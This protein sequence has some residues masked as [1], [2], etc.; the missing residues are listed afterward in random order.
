MEKINQKKSFLFL[1]SLFILTF[2]VLI[3]SIVNAQQEPNKKDW[4]YD[5]TVSNVSCY[6]LIAVCGNKKVVFLKF[7]N[8]NSNPIKISWKEA[9]ITQPHS[10]KTETVFGEKELLLATGETSLTDCENVKQPK[11]LAR[12]NAVSPID[13]LDIL[14]FSFKDLKVAN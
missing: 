9:F 11:L 7:D 3:V 10:E 13:Q 5:S 4:I 8:K 2:L 12:P 14:Q 1:K 6:H